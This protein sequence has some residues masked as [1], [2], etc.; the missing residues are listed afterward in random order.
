ML[1]IN[2]WLTNQMDQILRLLVEEKS[3]VTNSFSIDQNCAL[4]PEQWSVVQVDG[5]VQ[6][7]HADPEQLVMDFGTG[8]LE[9]ANDCT[10]L[11]MDRKYASSKVGSL[12]WSF[13]GF[14]GGDI[15]EAG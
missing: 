9:P 10:L 14:C 15:Y 12:V 13:P 8:T 7:L 11:P 1:K 5:D 6:S 2:P 4:Q 3:V